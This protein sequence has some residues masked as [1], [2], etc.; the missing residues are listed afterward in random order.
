MT[1]VEQVLA[2]HCPRPGD[3]PL[4]IPWWS[5]GEYARAKGTKW[6][7]PD[8]T[9]IVG[10]RIV[11]RGSGAFPSASKAEPLSKPQPPVQKRS[12]T[13]TRAPATPARSKRPL[14]RVDEL[15]QEH[16]TLDARTVLCFQHGINPAILRDAPNP[17]VASMRLANALRK[18]LL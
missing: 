9:Q 12:E 10:G 4:Y 1:T 15:L 3:D 7:M 18:V 5:K 8:G 2:E 6:A 17:G 14:D 16:R 11:V 13:P